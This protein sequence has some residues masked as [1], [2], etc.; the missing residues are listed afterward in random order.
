M[1]NIRIH[2][3]EAHLKTAKTSSLKELMEKFGVSSA[4]IHRDAEALAKRGS[5]RRVSGGLVYI[6]P[7]GD[8]PSSPSYE[9][10]IVS[11]R[12]GKLLAA[13]KA[14]EL[15]N[16]GDIIFLDSSTTVHEIAL[17]LCRR[18]F[19]SL[20]VVTNAIPVMHLFR[21]MPAHW[22]LVGL[23]GNFDPQLN[24]MLGADTIA[25]FSRCAVDKAFVSA[26]GLDGDAATTNHERQAELLWKVLAA[27][28]K[29]YLVVDSTKIGRKGLYRIAI[30]TAFDEIV[31]E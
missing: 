3:I 28:K 23:G 7:E 9:E 6:G 8:D 1:D 15:I 2:R 18:A 22:S 13:Q 4:T 11:N 29:R 17:L 12:S 30:R 19:A 26:F 25:Q 16:D 14:V 24:A 20:T 21:K 5:A 27:S 31:T 10:R